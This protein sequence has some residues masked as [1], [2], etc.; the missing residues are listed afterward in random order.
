MRAILQRVSQALVNVDNEVVGSIGHGLV[1]YVGVHQ[2]DTVEDAKKL[3]HKIAHAR[4]FEDDQGKMN[5]SVIDV[6]GEVLSI[7]QFTLYGETKKGHR[8]SY[9]KAA[10]PE[11]A[12]LLYEAFNTELRESVPVKTG[13]FQAHM[14]IDQTNDGPVTLVYE[15]REANL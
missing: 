2:E 10:R 8:P 4:V 6:N 12:N 14:I 9:D 13:I 15:T 3:A 11:P 1:V 7:S 5:L